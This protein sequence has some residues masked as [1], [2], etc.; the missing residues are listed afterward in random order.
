MTTQF[1]STNNTHRKVPAQW[2]ALA[3]LCMTAALAS[4]TFAATCTT[5]SLTLAANQWRLVGIPCVPNPATVGAVFSS[6]PANLVAANYN[7]TWVLWK[8]TYTA[9]GDSYTKMAVGD[10]VT[11]GGAYWL[12]TTVGSTL[13]VNGTATVSN[14]PPFSL[15]AS[16]FVN[17][18]PAL[19]IPASRYILYAN[20]W[21]NNS[22]AWSALLL[23]V[24][25]GAITIPNVS[26]ANAI[27]ANL[28]SK[29]VNYWNGNTYFTRDNVGAPGVPA[30]T[31]A[32]N[33]SAWIQALPVLSNVAS[34][35]IKANKPP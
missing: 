27:V 19:T 6:S 28:V 18:P 9:S 32:P 34:F 25:T 11:T 13:Q 16:Y 4:P 12:Y 2:L 29:D 10:T 20:P 35:T 14:G 17:G 23:S 24:T 8:R 22:V 5:T 7:V 21:A 3:V 1:E 30:A 26:I 31:F 33:E 15:P